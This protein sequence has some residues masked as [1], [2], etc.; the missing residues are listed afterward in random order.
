MN[1]IVDLKERLAALEARIAHYERMTDDLSEVIARQDRAIDLM[2][3][4][5]QR[6]LERLRAVETGADRSP[7]DDR[8]PPHY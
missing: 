2:A 4:K 7:Q 1:G 8:P 5:L 6:L 3:A